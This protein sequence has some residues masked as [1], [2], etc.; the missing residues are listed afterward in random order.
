MKDNNSIYKLNSKAEFVNL[1]KRNMRRA[2]FSA[3]G[4]VGNH[5][6][7]TIESG[8]AGGGQD[9]RPGPISL[10]GDHFGSGRHDLAHLQ[11]LKHEQVGQQMAFSLG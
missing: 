11:L 1:V 7:I 5:H 6:R 8:A 9:R 4:F 2:Y 10:Q 3:L